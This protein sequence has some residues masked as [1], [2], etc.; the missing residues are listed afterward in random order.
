MITLRRGNQLFGTV[1]GKQLLVCYRNCWAFRLSSS[2]FLF[3]FFFGWNNCNESACYILSHLPLVSRGFRAFYRVLLFC[4]ICLIGYQR[5]NCVCIKT[6]KPTF[7]HFFH[8]QNVQRITHSSVAIARCS[9][10]FDF[11]PWVF[12]PVH[13]LI[14][15][16]FISFLFS[17]FPFSDTP[18]TNKNLEGGANL[19]DACSFASQCLYSVCTVE[20]F[21]K[22]WSCYHKFV[23]FHSCLVILPMY[24]LSAIAL[25][26]F[27][28]STSY[29]ISIF[30]CWIFCY[31]FWFSFFWACNVFKPM[32]FGSI[33][34]LLEDCVFFFGCCKIALIY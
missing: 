21:I 7:S 16:S 4:Q 12:L 19:Y 23:T 24:C 15:V 14:V 22:Y 1:E 5:W 29:S 2:V 6:E 10:L 3:F 11:F 30:Q 13:R 27:S 26:F 28:S 17:I 33:R 18:M 8:A 25:C 9:I 20:V 31:C 32:L 34:D